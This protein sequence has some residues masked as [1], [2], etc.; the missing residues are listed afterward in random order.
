MEVFLDSN[1][2]I[3]CIKKKIDFLSKLEEQGFRIILPR[4]VFQE[5]KD[6]RLKLHHED[7]IAIDIALELFNSKK[8]EKV[9]L[10]GLS[11]DEGLILKGKK[12]AYIATLDN[13][14]RHIVPNKIG[15]SDYS[16]NIL[17]ERT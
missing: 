7:K 10:S 17:I 12:G 1:F 6:L 2:I 5:L 16:K 15:I 11:V 14:I 8:I 4:E 3:Y 9:T 13:K